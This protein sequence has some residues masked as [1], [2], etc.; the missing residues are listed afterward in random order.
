MTWNHQRARW[1]HYDFLVWKERE[2]A[3][4]NCKK[5]GMQTFYSLPMENCDY[6]AV[7]LRLVSI[8]V[9]ARRNEVKATPDRC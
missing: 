4:A 5:G 8:A 9:R 1:A 2:A 3:R 6:L 7:G